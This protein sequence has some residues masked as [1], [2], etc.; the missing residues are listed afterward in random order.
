MCGSKL[1]YATEG[2]Y[3]LAKLKLLVQQICC[4]HELSCRTLVPMFVHVTRT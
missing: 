3:S 4:V 2:G 1:F